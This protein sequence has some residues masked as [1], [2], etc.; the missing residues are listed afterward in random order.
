MDPEVEATIDEHGLVGDANRGGLR[1]ITLVS[2]ERW[3]ELM[4]KVGASLGPEA[5]RA[6]LIVSGI[7]LTDTLGRTIVIGSCRLL[8]GG[9]TRPCEMMEEAATGLQEA[10]KSDWGGGVYATVRDGSCIAIGDPVR[11]DD[12]S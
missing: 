6:N 5:R 2:N 8:I 7:D 9:E 12:I 1:P 4:K 11:W 3:E 10:M